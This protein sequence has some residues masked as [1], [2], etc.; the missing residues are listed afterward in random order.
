MDIYTTSPLLR[1]GNYLGLSNTDMVKVYSYISNKDECIN[2]ITNLDL[3]N[4]DELHRFIKVL[5]DPSIYTYMDIYVMSIGALRYTPKIID[6][7]WI[8]MT[9]VNYTIRSLN[10]SEHNDCILIKR[11]LGVLNIEQ[12][13]WRDINKIRTFL[14][15]NKTPNSV[16]TIEGLIN[17][18]LVSMRLP[19]MVGSVG[20]YSQLAFKEYSSLVSLGYIRFLLN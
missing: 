20:I 7:N 2:F 12:S 9:W 17:I 18:G 4:G 6:K 10:I 11:L 19:N 1:I 8:Y 14:S 16:I 5:E 15:Y 13:G 3:L